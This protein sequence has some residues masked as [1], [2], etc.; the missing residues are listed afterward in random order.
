MIRTSRDHARKTRD[1]FA[2]GAGD[3]ELIP[4]QRSGVRGPRHITSRNIF[5]GRQRAPQR[6]FRKW[7]PIEPAMKRR[8]KA[9]YRPVELNPPGFEV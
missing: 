6:T 5:L 3:S 8:E 7:G 2:A 1:K 9:S 4:R